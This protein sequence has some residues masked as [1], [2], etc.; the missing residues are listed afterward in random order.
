MINRNAQAENYLRNLI[1]FRAVS[2]QSDEAIESIIS[3]MRED[4]LLVAKSSGGFSGNWSVYVCA[5]E[6]GKWVHV[7]FKWGWKS[8]AY[9]LTWASSEEGAPA[10]YSA[11]EED[12]R[13]VF[14]VCER[15]YK[16]VA[17]YD[18][19]KGEFAGNV[20]RNAIGLANARLADRYRYFTGAETAL[21]AKAAGESYSEESLP[22][23][24]EWIKA[25]QISL[26]SLRYMVEIG[27]L[28]D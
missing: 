4:G 28:D 8:G 6:S 24:G 26:G 27:A 21:E 23:Y 12:A 15:A 18:V 1:D 10:S 20:R 14:R 2:G 11:T 25:A 16:A 13:V 5:P 22:T 17:P 3:Q 7:A 19:P 9:F